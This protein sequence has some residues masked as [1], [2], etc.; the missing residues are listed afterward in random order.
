MPIYEY[1]CDECGSHFERIFMSPDER[2]EEMTCP[3]CESSEVHRIFS[4]P[5]V[6]SGEGE[7]LEDK[8]SD[9]TSDEGGRQPGG[10]NRRGS[11]GIQAA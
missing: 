4:A 10:L 9:Q 6:Y 7:S 8:I 2:P 5:S 1:T 3:E 11:G